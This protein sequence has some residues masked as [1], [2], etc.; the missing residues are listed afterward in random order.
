M[1]EASKVYLTIVAATA[2]HV[3]ILKILDEKG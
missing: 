1:S 2:G 3:E